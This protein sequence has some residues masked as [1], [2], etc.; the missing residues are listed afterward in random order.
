MKLKGLVDEDFIN[1]KTPSLFLI[2]PYCTF[3][4]GKEVCQNFNLINN[5]IIEVSAKSVI[6]RYLANSI[7]RSIVF[8]GLEPFDSFEDVLEFI[9]LI[10]TDYK[11][12]D[13]IVIYT[14]YTKQECKSWIESLSKYCNIIIKFGRFKPNESYHFD[15]VLGIQLSSNN[16][17]AEKIS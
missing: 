8:G 16:Q 6:E 15:D 12:N 1:Y 14:G 10:R 17:Y 3:K 13:D 7:T 9:S 11:C 2:F 5:S 4:C